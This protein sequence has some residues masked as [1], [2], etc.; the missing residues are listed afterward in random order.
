MTLDW[1]K[2]LVWLSLRDPRAAAQALFA[3]NLPRE[4]R[5]I[6]F[7]LVVVLSAALGTLAEVVFSFVTKVDLGPAQSPVPLALMQGGLLL[8]GAMMITFMGQR[9][10]GSGRFSDA[11]LALSWIEFVLILGQIVQM[12]VM[13]FFPLVSVVVTLGLIGLMFWMLVNFVAVL[14]G[15]DNLLAVTAGVIVGFIASALLAGIVLVSL[16][17]VPVPTPA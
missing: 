14:H 1:I 16:G 4:A 5:R 6:G 11:L 17:V 13:V 7:V 9:S 3:L 8:Y 2:A 15:F 10:G 12:L